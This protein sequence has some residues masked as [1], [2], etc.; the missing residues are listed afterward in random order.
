VNSIPQLKGLD[1]KAA[2]SVI[3]HGYDA[4]GDGGGGLFAWTTDMTIDKDGGL[5]VWPEVT[6]RTGAW[7]R[8]HTSPVD[9]RWFGAHAGADSTSAIQ[10]AIR[11]GK[12]VHIPAGRYIVSSPLVLSTRGQVVSG[13]GED[14]TILDCSAAA[15][16]GFQLE[17]GSSF[18]RIANLGLHGTSA[19]DADTNAGVNVVDATRFLLDHVYITGFAFGYSAAGAKIKSAIVGSIQA[20][21]LY[22]NRIA[23]VY[24]AN[25]SDA[26]KIGGGTEIGAGQYGVIAGTLVSRSARLDYSKNGN[27]APSLSVTNCVIEGQSR[28]GVYIETGCTAVTVRDC[29]FEAGNVAPAN[30]TSYIQL[31]SKEAPGTN[32]IAPVIEGNVFAPY[33]LA[34]QDYHAIEVGR[35]SGGS[36]RGNTV[37]DPRQRLLKVSSAGFMDILVEGNYL[38]GTDNVSDAGTIGCSQSW[39]PVGTANG[40]VGKR[41]YLHDAASGGFTNGFT[42]PNTSDGFFDFESASVR[43][44]KDPQ[45]KSD[46]F[47]FGQSYGLLADAGIRASAGS[48]TVHR[49]TSFVQRQGNVLTLTI[50]ANVTTT[51]AA[52]VLFDVSPFLGANTFEATPDGVALGWGG[53]SQSFGQPSGIYRYSNTAIAMFLNGASDFAPGVPFDLCGS[54]TLYCAPLT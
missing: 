35:V 28:V 38:P 33:E 46:T 34:S 27:P 17:T 4:P 48:L 22:D 21:Y 2:S 1:G 51:Q 49:N 15:I 23:G 44:W 29:Y 11:T 12:A 19:S 16:D 37:L 42:I 52:Y 41:Y 47:A 31:G 10:A 24:A 3:V 32:V 36:I 43:F 5:V 14:A 26:L 18:I 20:C 13:A 50:N 54:V 25:Y 39:Y 40:F 7:L 45:F 9:V 30:R 53:N 6:P 8:V